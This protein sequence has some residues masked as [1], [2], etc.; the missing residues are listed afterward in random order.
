[1]TSPSFIEVEVGH[2]KISF[3]DNEVSRWRVETLRTKEPDTIAWIDG[4]EPNSVF[5]D[6]GANI[7]IYSLYAAALGHS[8]VAFEPLPVHYAQ[9]CVNAAQSGLGVDVRAR[10]M[11]IGSEEAIF[12][13]MKKYG[14]F[15]VEASSLGGMA[16]AQVWDAPPPLAMDYLKIDT[17]GADLDVIRGL[18]LYGRGH[19]RPKEIQIE[20]DVEREDAIQIG[21]L[22]L[23]AGYTQKRRSICP[24]T[25]NSPIGNEL[26]QRVSGR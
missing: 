21:S 18:G 25:P 10:H 24:F 7:G 1:M 8:V 4:F 12:C 9:L 5:W 6:V 15:I 2:Q 19:H 20:V 11:W 22:L 14:D 16:T 23:N 26:W 13:G 17:D 3:L